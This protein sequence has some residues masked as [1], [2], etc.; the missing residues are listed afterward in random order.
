L[1]LE[2]FIF[3][4]IAREKR[5]TNIAE[6]IL[7]MWQ[8]E[9][10]LRACQFNH[11]LIEVHLVNRFEADESIRMEISGWYNSLARAMEMEQI[12]ETGHL[13]SVKN[14]VRDLNEFH[15]KMLERQVDAD[16]LQLYRMNSGAISEF[17]QKTGKVVENEVEACLNALFGVLLLKLQN[18]EIT[19]E[20]KIIID[21]FGRLMGHLSAR[22]IQFE[23]DEFEF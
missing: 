18:K 21:G 8:V 19:P 9:D 15:L 3:M 12:T 1:E 17:M 23:N 2:T 14:A 20:T 6:Y 10:L 11:E 7:Y 22:Y 13:Q 5:T 16:Y 4:L